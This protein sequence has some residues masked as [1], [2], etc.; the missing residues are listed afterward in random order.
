MISVLFFVVLQCD[1]FVIT[2]RHELGTLSV[3][4]PVHQFTY[5]FRN[6]EDF[7]PVAPNGR[8]TDPLLIL[9]V[10][11][12]SWNGSIWTLNVQS[13]TLMMS[14]DSCCLFLLLI[15]LQQMLNVAGCVLY[16]R[17]STDL[18]SVI[19]GLDPGILRYRRQEALAAYSAASSYCCSLGSGSLDQLVDRHQHTSAETDEASVTGFKQERKTLSHKQ[20]RS[21]VTAK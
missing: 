18:Q 3:W 6:N 15:K 14:S 9:K 1:D 4:V 12:T 11:R 7:L 2:R 20:S 8:R 21:S 5:C 17:P 16:H 13:Q 10:V 19:P